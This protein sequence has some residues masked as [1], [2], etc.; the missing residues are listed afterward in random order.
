MSQWVQQSEIP[1]AW[2]SLDSQDNDLYQFWSYIIAAFDSKTP[3][4]A[5]AM[6]P[7]LS[8]LKTGAVEPLLAA[9]I[10]EFSIRGEELA[11][12]LDDYHT[13]HLFSIHASVVRLLENVPENIHLY[14][15]SH[16]Q[17]P[18]PAAGGSAVCILLRYRCKAVTMFTDLFMLSMVSIA[19]YPIIFFRKCF[20]ISL[21]R[22]SLFSWKVSGTFQTIEFACG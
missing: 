8:A 3:S 13:I 6:D 11:I 17:L 15:A 19:L 9:M 20:A 16:I 12:I 22:F 1:A 7:Y 2:V 18:F 10:H 14:I 5:T 4:F 21:K